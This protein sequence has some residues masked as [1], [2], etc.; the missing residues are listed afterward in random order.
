VSCYHAFIIVVGLLWRDPMVFICWL[1]VLWHFDLS[2]GDDS[3][4]VETVERDMFHAPLALTR[5]THHR[6]SNTPSLYNLR[7]AS[8]IRSRSVTVLLNITKQGLREI[9]RRENNT[10]R[11]LE[12][13]LSC[14]LLQSSHSKGWFQT[15]EMKRRLRHLRRYRT[16]CACPAV[17]AHRKAAS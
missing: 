13:S 16:L 9:G 7:L 3:H 11:A 10:T 8:V 14:D 5:L 2:D 17:M 4:R 1:V 12:N 15:V 6:Y